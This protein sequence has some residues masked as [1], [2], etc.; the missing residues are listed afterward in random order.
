MRKEVQS[1]YLH[2]KH[3]PDV[4]VLVLAAK[5]KV[6][7]SGKD[8]FEKVAPED[9]DGSVLTNDEVYKFQRSIF[10]PI[11]CVIDGPCLAQGAG[12]ALNS[13]VVLMS[14]KGSIGW[15]QVKRGISTVSGPTFCAQ[16]IP[17]VHA[18]G[19]LMRGKPIPAGECLRWGLANE[20]VATDQL[21]EV[22]LRWASEIME[23]APL[24]VRAVKEAARRGVD[25]AFEERMYM[26]RDVANSVLQS[27][28]SKEGVAAFREKR[29]PVWVGR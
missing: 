27:V 23:S 5:G 29:P 1:A 4:W 7:C 22:A 21:N 15:P 19:Y 24:A 11:I 9:E 25:M 26:A 12:F 10:K 16:A 2:V 8:L 14:E 18:M 3:D 28:D 17:W 13:D 6:F 20:V